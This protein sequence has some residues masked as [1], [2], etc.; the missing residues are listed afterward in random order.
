MTLSERIEQERMRRASSLPTL[1]DID[2]ETYATEA[3]A[4]PV[5]S[6]G[7]KY[8]PMP[9]VTPHATW[10]PN[11]GQS[12]TGPTYRPAWRDRL[13]ARDETGAIR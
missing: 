12:Y 3:K 11:V 7:P 2:P 6:A 9:A 8:G 13:T 10:C 1:S 4:C 5:C